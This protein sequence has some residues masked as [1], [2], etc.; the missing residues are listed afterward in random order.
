MTLPAAGN[1]IAISQIN[2]EFSLGN[3]LSAYRGVTWWTDAGATGTFD[4]TNLDMSEFYSKR[5][6]SPF[7]V[8]LA[9][10]NGT[11][12]VSSGYAVSIDLFMNTNGT[13]YIQGY[14]GTIATGNWGTPTT[15]GI[16][17]SYWVRFTRT[18]NVFP[19]S[20]A[21][22]STGWLQLSSNQSVTVYNNTSGG[23]V[24]GVYTV[25]ISTNSGGTAIVAT[26]TNVSLSAFNETG[27]GGGGI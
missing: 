22:P 2:T 16:G 9:T 14:E 17:S 19:P 10:L 6:N 27:G 15:A 24:T 3:S 7:T 18:T 11:T 4:S 5:V 23:V 8:S 20:T 26:A 21:S 12:T 1:S 13:W 25:E